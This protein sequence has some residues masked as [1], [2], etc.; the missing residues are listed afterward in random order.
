M[1]LNIETTVVGVLSILT[2][3]ILNGGCLCEQANE[4]LQPKIQMIEETLDGG[5][6][7]VFEGYYMDG[8][9]VEHGKCVLTEKDGVRCEMYYS[10]GLADGKCRWYYLDGSLA[11]EGT[12]VKNQPWDGILMSLGMCVGPPHRYRSGKDEGVWRDPKG[13]FVDE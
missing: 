3:G 1:L 9:S 10:H 12:Y 8:R 4:K 7:V 2:V 13:V 11:F 5:G 6:K